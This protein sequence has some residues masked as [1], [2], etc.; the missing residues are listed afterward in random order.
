MPSATPSA[1]PPAIEPPR[2]YLVAPPVMDAGGTAALHAVL[3]AADV[4]CLRVDDFDRDAAARAAEAVMAV[5]APRDIPVVVT[6][7]APLVMRLGLDGCH[8]T[9]AAR[10]R[11][12]RKEWG[13]GPIIG[14]GCGA[15]RHH[16]M[17]AGE[18]GADYVAFDAAAGADLFGWWAAA[19][20]V[21]LVLD[22]TDDADA[23]RALAP[24]IDFATLGGALWRADDPAARVRMLAATL[25]EAARG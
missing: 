2:L 13:G 22:A 1:T 9:D 23:I 8:V 24:R 7:H 25:A 20:E 6:D 18:D 17:V 14:A 4:A 12:L 10:V 15:S 19:I 21:P 3:D 11:V 5:A 16:G